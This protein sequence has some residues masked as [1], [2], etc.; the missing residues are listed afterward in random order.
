MLQRSAHV[1]S[2]NG[3]HLIVMLT[4]LLPV[5]LL[6]L[7]L[8]GTF[9]FRVSAASSFSAAA[10]NKNKND[11]VGKVGMDNNI[12]TATTAISENDNVFDATWIEDNPNYQDASDDESDSDDDDDSDDE[13]RDNTTKV[14]LSQALKNDDSDGQQ[15]QSILK[16]L[17]GNWT[18]VTLAVA[19]VAFRHELWALLQYIF[20]Q[21]G[22][23]DV[24]ATDLLKLVLFLDFMRRLLQ[25]QQQQ[26]TGNNIDMAPTSSPLLQNLLRNLFSSNP[27]FVPPLTQHYTFERCI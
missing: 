7:L 17:R 10:A 2:H 4:L 5:L 24:S 18:A 8:L 13:T 16:T 21:N 3:G 15:P 27:A 26:Q 6:L 19:A 11:P 23:K 9:D 20:R 1:R 12:T 14:R 25:Q 22:G